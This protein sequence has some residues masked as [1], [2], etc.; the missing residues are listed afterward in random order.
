[1]PPDPH[2]F[3]EKLRRALVKAGVVEEATY[4]RE[5]FALRFPEGGNLFLTN[6][7]DEY[8]RASFFS[9]R[10]TLKRWVLSAKEQREHQLPATFAE[11]Q[12]N[13]LPQLRDLPYLDQVRLM[14]RIQSPKSAPMFPTRPLASELV[15]ALAYDSPRTIA[16]LAQQVLDDWGVSLDEAL[17]P[18]QFNLRARTAQGLVLQGPGVFVSPYQDNYDASRI[19]LTELIS[20]LAV[21]GDPVAFVPHR[22]SLIVT[23]SEDSEGLLQACAL[24]EPLLKENRRISG[25]PLVFRGGR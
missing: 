11:A 8:R 19:V 14:Q 13:L 9:R 16:T 20:R 1:M 6:A 24:A 4:D 7:F 25:Q 22:D 18:A 17:K 15:V 2:V 10:A 3:A 12:A 23:G 21:K 5:N